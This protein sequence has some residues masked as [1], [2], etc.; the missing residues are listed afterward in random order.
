VI[1][2]M[3]SSDILHGN[4]ARIAPPEYCGGVGARGVASLR[5][6]VTDGGRLVLLDRAC[7]L[8]TRNLKSGVGYVKHTANLAAPGSILRIHLTDEHPVTWGYRRSLPVMVTDSPVFDIADD[9]SQKCLGW[10]DTR[11][12]LLSGWLPE[13]HAR[14]GACGL[15]QVELGHGSITFFGFR[16]QFRGHALGAYRLLFNALTQPRTLKRQERSRP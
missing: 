6:F 10:F 5:R 11:D 14:R 13:D 4:N 3:S 15:A 2:S 1:A 8:G 9:P 12:P 16:P 7:D